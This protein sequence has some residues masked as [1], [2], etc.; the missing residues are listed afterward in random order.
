MASPITLEQLERRR[1][2]MLIGLLVGFTLWMG[3][4]LAHR[5]GTLGSVP[6]AA[7]AWTVGVGT[8]GW[9]FY[10]FNFFRMVRMKRMLRRDPALAAAADD[11][12]RKHLRLK[13][14]ATAFWVLLVLQP[15]LGM[16]LGTMPIR[17]GARISLIVGV[18][19]AVGGFLLLDR[20]REAG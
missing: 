9:V 1:R 20:D 3:A 6:P 11:E 18:V 13:A 19:A 2:G 17:I 4:D 5:L 8:L 15:V 10:V 14:F 12:Y 16:T 7:V